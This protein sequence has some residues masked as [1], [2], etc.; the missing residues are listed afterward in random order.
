MRRPHQIVAGVFTTLLLLVPARALAQVDT[1]GPGADG[2]PEVLSGEKPQE[3]GIKIGPGRLHLYVTEELEYNSAAVV[4]PSSNTPGAPFVVDG[5]LILHTRP[6]FNLEV[7]GDNNSFGLSG[8]VDYLWY[9]G[10]ITPGDG[11]AS[12][13]DAAADLHGAF[14]K[15]GAIGFNIGDTFSRSANTYSPS[16]PVGVISLYNQ[17]RLEIPIRP[18]GRALEI[19]PHAAYGVEFFNQYSGVTPG[20]ATCADPASPCNPANLSQYNYQDLS[21]GL[22]VRLKF[23]PQTAFLFTSTYDARF[24]ADTTVNGVLVNPNASEL[25]LLVGLAGLITTKL[26][27]IFKVGWGQGFGDGHLS[28]V[29]GQ[30]E[31]KWLPTELASL[32]VGFLRDV[33]PVSG[34]GSYIDD[35]PYI[36]GKIFMGGR[37]SLGLTV[38]YDFFDFAR[39]DPTAPTTS[40]NDSQLSG[41][42]LCEY[43]VLRWFVLGAGFLVNHHTSTGTDAADNALNYTQWQPYVQVTLTY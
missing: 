26:A 30:A 41:N 1:V 2:T 31:V 32:A 38:S 40:R 37:L 15:N 9:T 20:N 35:R 34:N 16:I 14:N 21:S 13:L 10:V 17:A 4:L 19:V 8:D 6:G 29:I 11:S 23:L 3:N 25:K 22:D 39:G 5:E 7:D 42:L 28:T 27:V 33:Y 43:Q 18:G 12:R 24:Y 36:N